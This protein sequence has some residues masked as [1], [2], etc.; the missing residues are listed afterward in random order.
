MFIISPVPIRAGHTYR[1]PARV[2]IGYH[3]AVGDQSR[4]RP[5]NQCYLSRGIRAFRPS[6]EI[7]RDGHLFWC[8]FTAWRFHKIQE[9]S[10]ET[11][12]TR[13]T[14]K[15]PLVRI[16]PDTSKRCW[17][18]ALNLVQFNRFGIQSIHLPCHPPRL[19]QPREADPERSP[20]PLRRQVRRAY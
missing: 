17:F 9:L 18:R 4:S 7:S 20:G 8:A 10:T 6:R 2:P 14:D 15:E 13:T 16:R 19:W 5:T 1:V 12:I 3:P 11:D